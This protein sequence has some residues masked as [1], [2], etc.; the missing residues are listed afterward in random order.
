[1]AEDYIL[2]DE[3]VS[4]APARFEKVLRV[5]IFIALLCLCAKLVWLLGITPF[6]PFSRIDI[7]G[8]SGI[9]REAVLAQAG[10]TGAVSFF[11]ADTKAIETALMDSGV[12]ESVLVYKY[13][14]SRLQIIL[15]ERRPVAQA[16]VNING[17]TVP[18]LLDRQGVIFG[19]GAELSGMLPV[20][21][22][23]V[24][25]DPYPG[26]KLPAM[27]IS[28]FSGLERIMISSPELL[29]AVSELRINRRLFDGYDL[30]LYPVHT[31]IRVRL[32]ELNEDLLRYTFLMLDVLAFNEDSIDTLDFRSGI[33]SYKPLEVPSE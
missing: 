26:M 7:N 1:M 23:I 32:S 3:A 8:Y 28:L 21:S 2:A 31:R 17:R 16:L 30:T 15:D 5:F 24:I 4:V 13:F 14:P 9:N 11:S 12:F 29:G 19:I 20:I 18:L 10:V 27:F 25:E 22:G 33:A 6:K